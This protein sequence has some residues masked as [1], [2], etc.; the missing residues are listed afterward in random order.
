VRVAGVPARP[1][2]ERQL[3]LWVGG[4]M[5]LL[6][7]T[8]LLASARPSLQHA[9]VLLVLAPLL[10]ESFFRAGVQEHL[11]RFVSSPGLAVVLTAL[12]FAASHALAGSDPRRFAV[13][14]PALIIGAVYARTGRVRDCVL[15]HTGLNAVWLV[16]RAVV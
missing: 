11:A 8:G 14:L 13:V 7:V 12:L 6:A 3:A 5:V 9:W 15:L 1:V 4:A 2:A 10:E 16:A